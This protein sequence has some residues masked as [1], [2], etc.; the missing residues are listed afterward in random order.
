MN[1]IFGFV[2]HKGVQ[3]LV[4]PGTTAWLY[5]PLPNANIEECEKYRHLKC[6]KNNFDKN[7]S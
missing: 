1:N 4:M 3:S 5:I 6:E 7:K 2:G